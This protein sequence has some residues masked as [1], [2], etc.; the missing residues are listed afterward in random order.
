MNRACAPP[1]RRRGFVELSGKNYGVGLVA[2]LQARK[3]CAVRRIPNQRGG[4]QRGHGAIRPRCRPR[5]RLRVASVESKSR[6]YPE[7]RARP[8]TN[9][10]AS[11]PAIWYS[12]SAGEY[13]AGTSSR[14]LRSSARARHSRATNYPRRAGILSGGGIFSSLRL[15]HVPCD[16][17]RSPRIRQIKVGRTDLPGTLYQGVVFVF[18]HPRISF[19]TEPP[20]YKIRI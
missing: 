15:R 8:P 4:S 7:G 2:R 13:E 6:R 1:V 17:R 9:G 16:R 3:C 11:G 5:W 19:I 10:S 20:Y 18:A 12:G 14:R